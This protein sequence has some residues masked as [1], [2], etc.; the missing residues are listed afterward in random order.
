MDPIN[1]LKDGENINKP[2]YSNNYDTNSYPIGANTDAFKREYI[3]SDIKNVNLFQTVNTNDDLHQKKINISPS[4]N[5]KMALLKEKYVY[6]NLETNNEQN[7]P[8][9]IYLNNSDMNISG[10]ANNTHINNYGARIK[11]SNIESTTKKKENSNNSD[12]VRNLFDANK[13]RIQK[14]SEANIA[15]NNNNSNNAKDNG[16]K[17][18]LTSILALDKMVEECDINNLMSTNQFKDLYSHHN[19]YVDKN[20]Q[21]E[22]NNV[23]FLN[24]YNESKNITQMDHNTLSNKIDVSHLSKENISLNKGYD[25]YM[26]NKN[27]PNTNE[28]NLSGKYIENT[29]SSEINKNIV[30]PKQTIVKESYMTNNISIDNFSKFI[31]NPQNENN[32]IINDEEFCIQTRTNM[33]GIPFNDDHN[34]NKFYDENKNINNF[35]NTRNSKPTNVYTEEDENNIQNN[36]FEV[37]DYKKNKKIIYYN[38]K[39]HY[40]PY[41]ELK[42]KETNNQNIY[43]NKIYENDIYDYLLHQYE[44][45][46]KNIMEKKFSTSNKSFANEQNE[47]ILNGANLKK[48]FSR[49]FK[50]LGISSTD[51]KK[52]DTFSQYNDQNTN[53][54]INYNDY[55]NIIKDEKNNPYTNPSNSNINS[56]SNDRNMSDI[57]PLCEENRDTYFRSGNS[58]DLSNDT[59]MDIF[60]NTKEVYTE[61]P[62]LLL[63]YIK[64]D[65]VY[66]RDFKSKIEKKKN[67]DEDILKMNKGI[68]KKLKK[69]KYDNTVVISNIGR[70]IGSTTFS[71]QIISDT[72]A[73][74]NDETYFTVDNNKEKN[75]IYSYI[76]SNENQINYVYLDYD[77][78][79]KKEGTPIT[80]DNTSNI[81]SNETLDKEILINNKTDITKKENS[82]NINKLLTFSFYFSNIIMIHIDSQNC[83]EIFYLLSDYYDIIKNIQNDIKYREKKKQNILEEKK[84]KTGKVSN[85]N[86]NNNDD[87]RNIKLAD[88]HDRTRGQKYSKLDSYA[89]KSSLDVSSMSLLETRLKEKIDENNSD[90]NSKE[91]SI[92]FDNDE[93]NKQNEGLQVPHFFFILRDVNENELLNFKDEN[94]NGSLSIHQNKDKINRSNSENPYN[95]TEKSE[96]NNDNYTQNYFNFLINKIKNNNIKKKVK[97][98]IKFLGKKS[99]FLFPSL[100]KNNNDN[101]DETEITAQYMSELKNL[102]KELYIQGRSIDNMHKHDGKYMYK[103]L[104]MLIYTTNNNIFYSPNHIKKKIERFE[105]KILY[106]ILTDNFLLHIRNKIE[107]KLPMKPNLFLTLINQI[108]IE[109][110]VTFDKF[111]IGNTEIKNRYRTQLCNNIDIIILKAYKENIAYSCFTFYNLIDNKISELNIYENINKKN[112][113]NFD[114]L[115]KDINKLNKQGI[116]NLIYNEILSI[117][118]EEMFTHFINTY[119]DGNISP[120]REEDVDEKSDYESSSFPRLQ[121]DN[122]KKKNTYINYQSDDTIDSVGYNKKITKKKSSIGTKYL[123]KNENM[124]TILKKE[125]NKASSK[126]DETYDYSDCSNNSYGNSM[127]NKNRNLERKKSNS[128][129]HSILE[130]RRSNISRSISN[131][132]NNK[133]KNL[134]EQNKD[135]NTLRKGNRSSSNNFSINKNMSINLDMLVKRYNRRNSKN[136]SR[137]LL[138][139]KNKSDLE[140][141]NN[142]KKNNNYRKYKTDEHINTHSNN[143]K[144]YMTTNDYLKNIDLYVNKKM[145][146]TDLNKPKNTSPKRRNTENYGKK[147]ISFNENNII[148]NS[149]T[150]GENKKNIFKDE[151]FGDHQFWSFEK[152]NEDNFHSNSII[153]N[154]NIGDNKFG[155]KI[156]NKNGS[157]IDAKKKKKINCFPMNKKR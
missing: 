14:V 100:C 68:K 53:E 112:Y 152:K 1:I 113:Q 12:I 29:F 109:F 105:N 38:V 69:M 85:N 104:N 108:K 42:K 3:H 73:I 13:F 26:N 71:N 121:K 21:T 24:A 2:N 134:N 132:T 28:I 87:E 107:N 135:T 34:S 124:A 45:N 41:N 106:N 15:K 96:S 86:R 27:T 127:I 123:H 83:L 18:N 6:Q 36:L 89:T 16:A 91:D 153:G 10:S 19:K 155:I 65:P 94:K 142:Q 60:K 130:K 43:D 90:N 129:N 154:S 46:Y 80:N 156:E 147:K 138:Q 84:K 103:Y 88:N 114:H 37:Y 81:S 52:M 149:K 79:S 30:N 7:Y 125:K 93:E 44:T 22:S 144:K 25:N 151:Y 119:Y 139:K 70:K 75:C 32:K 143:I 95:F 11:I 110:L 56:D 120:S 111:S 58:F 157:N 97:Y 59:S 4:E 39:N 72:S 55:K 48:K 141:N 31:E 136:N 64:E 99:L 49:I 5:K 20:Y 126:I 77:K 131:K 50:N 82:H 117:K 102:K 66:S 51:N 57:T 67:N 133:H 54:S 128:Y 116:D 23:V 9:N 76:V 35:N 146:T 63:N 78:L 101:N 40:N 115:R 150:F 92:I 33:N 74:L 145:N 98:L 8:S 140:L 118:K 17:K 47:F 122:L 148:K 137:A 62:I 61:K